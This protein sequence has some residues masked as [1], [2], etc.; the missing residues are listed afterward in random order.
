MD[1]YCRRWY[2][3]WLQG[4]AIQ[5]HCSHELDEAWSEVESQRLVI[6]NLEDSFEWEDIGKLAVRSFISACV[7]IG[8]KVDER[9][10]VFEYSALIATIG[11]IF[12][13]AER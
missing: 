10:E 13:A 12:Q 5:V 4:L 6:D 1:D 8:T 3:Q 11:E 2:H 7:E 9:L